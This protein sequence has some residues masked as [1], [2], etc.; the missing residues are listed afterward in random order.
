MAPTRSR[1]AWLRDWISRI[2]GKT[3][4]STD[5]HVIFCEAC[6]QQV[7]FYNISGVLF[8]HHKQQAPSGQFFQLKQHDQTA[9]HLDNVRRSK[10]KQIN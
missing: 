5:G 3:I 8:L 2:N 4:Y 1:A 10:E 6:Q 9:K 7:Y